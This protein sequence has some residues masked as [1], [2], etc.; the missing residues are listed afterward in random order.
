MIILYKK[1][2]KGTANSNFHFVW[3]RDMTEKELKGNK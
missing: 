2:K 1:Q 3:I